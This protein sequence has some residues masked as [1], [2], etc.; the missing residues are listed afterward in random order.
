VGN[1]AIAQ[2]KEEVADSVV[3][4]E[5][6]ATATL[7]GFAPQQILVTDTLDELALYQGAARNEWS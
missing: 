7:G 2:E 6:G 1:S 3:A 5:F 4:R